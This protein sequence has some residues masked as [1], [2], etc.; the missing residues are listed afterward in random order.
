MSVQKGKASRVG[1]VGRAQVK[2]NIEAREILFQALQSRVSVVEF[3]VAGEL[4]LDQRLE[5]VLITSGEC[6]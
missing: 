1:W 4:T 6:E 5:A 2:V 3:Q